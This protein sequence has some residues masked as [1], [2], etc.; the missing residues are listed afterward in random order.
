MYPAPGNA[1]RDYKR[2]TFHGVG[3]N[4]VYK[5]AETPLVEI[6]AS[7]RQDIVSAQ[8]IVAEELGKAT[9][10]PRDRCVQFLRGFLCGLTCKA[11]AP[12][13]I[14]TEKIDSVLFLQP[15]K[16]QAC[17]NCRELAELIERELPQRITRGWNSNGG[18]LRKAFQK[19]V[20][21]TAGRIGL[22]LA[23]PGRTRKR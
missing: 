4:W 15:E 22:A 2:G 5:V 1:T 21:V 17:K 23:R 20:E 14:V 9:Q 8:R 19:R 10:L 11:E 16:V 3:L 18:T 7:A 6:S 13:D 12:V